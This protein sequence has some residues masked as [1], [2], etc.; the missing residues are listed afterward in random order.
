MNTPE[1][2]TSL[3]RKRT[4]FSS[5]R[6][7]ASSILTLL[8]LAETSFAVPITYTSQYSA[9]A[10]PTATAAT[11]SDPLW[12]LSAS[13]TGSSAAI[14]NGNLAAS[15]METTGTNQ[16]FWMLGN[17]AGS[18]VGTYQAWSL[19]S[20]TGVTVDFNL[21]VLETKDNGGGSSSQGGGFMI[22]VADGSFGTSLYFGT[23]SII[24]TGASSYTYTPTSFDLTDFNTFRI[25]MQ[26]GQVTLY[27]SNSETPIF[28]A[29]PGSG[30]LANYN[31]ILMGDFTSTYSGSYNLDYIAWNNTL[32][33][34]SAPVPEPSTFTFL[35]CLGI[36]WI[37][38][39]LNSRISPRDSKTV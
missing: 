17:N 31:R 11:V 22:Q 28:T 23:S 2:T 24:I 26:N 27:S 38:Y 33:E 13:G 21:Q 37:F 5:K 30:T 12:V 39:S 35:G 36:F 18:T 29:L 34:F 32:A 3:S 8:L 25:T 9:N 20:A 7:I 6:L 1:F 19:N 4:L 16:Q 15:T 14:V 10:L